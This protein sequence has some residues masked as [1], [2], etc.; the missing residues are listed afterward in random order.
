MSY[1]REEKF[2]YEPVADSLMHQLRC[3][4]A[5]DATTNS[6]DDATLRTTDIPNA[7]NLLSNKLFLFIKQISTQVPN[8]ERAVKYH[9]PVCLTPTD[10]ENEP[11]DHLLSSWRVSHLR[12]ELDTVYGFRIV[13]NGGEGGVVGLANGM[14]VWWCLGQLIAVRHPN[15]R[16]VCILGIGTS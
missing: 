16:G 3:N 7:S 9:G 15:L 4:G 14:E 1:I 8:K 6:T 11:S 10:V 12:V 13:S 5:V 2:Q